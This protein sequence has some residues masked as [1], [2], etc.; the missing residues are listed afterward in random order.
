LS[1][2][3]QE[4]IWLRRLLGNYGVAMDTATMIHEDNQG[5]IDLSRN[6]KHHNRT[7]HIDVSYHFTRERI[8]SKE[9]DV[10]YVHTGDNTADIMTKGL[11]RIAYEKHRDSLGVR[12]C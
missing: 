9:I 5:A 7:K 8:A 10:C 4:A 1:Q 2:A 12:G 6:P 3:T 11:G